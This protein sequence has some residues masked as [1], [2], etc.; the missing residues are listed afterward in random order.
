MTYSCL[1]VEDCD[2]IRDIYGFCLK[3]SPYQIL[4]EAKNGSEAL[5]KI[6]SL[7][8]DIILLDLVLPEV[9]GF[10]V[11]SKVHE[12]S[13]KSKVIVVSSLDDQL[14]KQKAKNLGALMYIDKPFKKENLLKALEE[15]S[16][17]Y[18]GV[19]NG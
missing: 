6:K 7:Q 17:T 8:P 5:H 2:F 18:A 10:E 4:D 12:L 11:L 19:Q 3:N 16:H 15:V 14:Y 1:I 9:N 13:P